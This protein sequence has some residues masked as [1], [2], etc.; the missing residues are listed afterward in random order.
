[1]SLKLFSP[2]FILRGFFYKDL[3]VKIWRYSNGLNKHNEVYNK[4]LQYVYKYMNII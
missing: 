4:V 3:R 1:M 2:N